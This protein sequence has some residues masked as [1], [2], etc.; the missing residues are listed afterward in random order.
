VEQELVFQIFFELQVKTVE[1]IIIF[2]VVVQVHLNI[3]AP[4]Q[5]VV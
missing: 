2:L 1:Q 4:Q 3:Q 5:L